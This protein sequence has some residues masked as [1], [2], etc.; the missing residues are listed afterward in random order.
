VTPDAPPV[1][2]VCNTMEAALAHIERLGEPNLAGFERPPPTQTQN[3]GGT[4]VRC[5][6]HRDETCSVLTI[7]AFRPGVRILPH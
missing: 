6:K 2:I 1:E 4:R 7:A 3:L 5:T